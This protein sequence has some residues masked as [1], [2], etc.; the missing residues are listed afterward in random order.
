MPYIDILDRLSYSFPHLPRLNL[1]RNSGIDKNLT[2]T[3]TN[4]AF[5][6]GVLVGLKLY[7]AEF[8][9]NSFFL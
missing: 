3:N 1:K 7:I 4:I 8:S 2:L 6:F 5:L 9:S